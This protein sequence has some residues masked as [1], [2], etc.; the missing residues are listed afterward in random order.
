M[1]YSI[2]NSLFFVILVK[3]Y[4][5]NE[6][7][8]TPIRWLY[9]YLKD[10]LCHANAVLWYALVCDAM[11]CDATVCC[12][13]LCY[14]MLCCA[15]LCYAMLCYAKRCAAMLRYV[16]LCHAIPEKARQG[17]ARQGTVTCDRSLGGAML[18]YA[19]QG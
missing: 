19:R 15:T 7:S 11:P 16:T 3:S 4:T 2:F 9:F 18:C 10:K 13:M 14:A 12:A 5:K 1:I 8:A 6:P 17:K